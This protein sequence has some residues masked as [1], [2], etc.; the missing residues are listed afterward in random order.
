M[1]LRLLVSIMGIFSV[2]CASHLA[3]VSFYCGEIGFRLHKW[4]ISRGHGE[5]CVS[6]Q[7]RVDMGHNYLILWYI[8]VGRDTMEKQTTSMRMTPD[9][10]RLL[11]LLA[12]HLG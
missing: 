12:K 7:S 10:K 5:S 1:I 4:P 11:E 9:G 8:S 6:G 2:C 3:T